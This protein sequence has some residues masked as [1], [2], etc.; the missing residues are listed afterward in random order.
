MWGADRR[1]LAGA[2]ADY[3]ARHIGWLIDRLI[4]PLRR[5]AK[6]PLWSE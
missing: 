6:P 5:M 2:V 4:D 3:L 1:D